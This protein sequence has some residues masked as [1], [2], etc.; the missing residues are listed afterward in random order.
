M[1]VI[2]RWTSSVLVVGLQGLWY[3]LTTASRCLAPDHVVEE[4]ELCLPF[5]HAPHEP[6]LGWARPAIARPRSLDPEALDGGSR[7]AS[8]AE[9]DSEPFEPVRRARPSLW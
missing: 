1:M 7:R 6:S 2:A 9:S 4:S 5:V 3:S 8:S